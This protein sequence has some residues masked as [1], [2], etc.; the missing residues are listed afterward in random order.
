M[1]PHSLC[2][3]SVEGSSADDASRK[4]SETP[5]P[6]A[7]NGGKKTKAPPIFF[8]RD[9]SKIAGDPGISALNVRT[10]Y[11]VLRVPVSDLFQIRLA[12]RTDP[13]VE[14][15]IKQCIQKM[16]SD[17][18]DER[19][20]AMDS[21]RDIGPDSLPLLRKATKSENEEIKNRADILVDE[22]ESENKKAA[23]EDISQVKGDQDIVTTR[24]FTFKGHVVE[25]SFSIGSRYGT[26]KISTKELVGITFKRGGLISK[27]LTV[28]GSKK[29]PSNWM[30]T[31]ISLVKGQSLRIRAT[32][33]LYVSNYS[34]TAGPG[35]T[36]RYSNSYSY[37]GIRPLALA[38]KIGKKGT[39]FLVGPNYRGKASKAGTLYLGVV[40]FRTYTP[41]GNFKVKI[42]GGE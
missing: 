25:D 36:T 6:P 37:K 38:G 17:D 12:E 18:F 31:K 33:Q 2:A 42:D 23:N 10:K 3:Q 40:P 20:E 26:L 21:L 16:G 35:G 30:S 27:S 24:K 4:K 39:P 19:E 34:L 15:S 13:A 5:I 1:L 9:G 22:I 11:G 32:G 8:L 14:K 41:T 29:V 28:D 7:E